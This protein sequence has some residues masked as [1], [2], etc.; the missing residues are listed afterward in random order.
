MLHDTEIGQ[1][2]EARIGKDHGF[3]FF[4]MA[5]AQVSLPTDP[6]LAPRG[7]DKLLPPANAA[8][9]SDIFVACV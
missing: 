6:C 9:A 2:S 1:M 7:A 3:P 8:H 4:P 5:A